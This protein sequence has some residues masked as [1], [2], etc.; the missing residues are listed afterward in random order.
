MKR[1]LRPAHL[2]APVIPGV[3]N[4]VVREMRREPRALHPPRELG[5]LVARERSVETPGFE[6]GFSTY[7]EIRPRG[8]RNTQ[9]VYQELSVSEPFVIARMSVAG[10]FRYVE[11][12]KRT[13]LN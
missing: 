5:I 6:I 13:R 3:N 11:D 1:F 8:S 9:L 10:E 7:N 2:D 4:Q 12:R